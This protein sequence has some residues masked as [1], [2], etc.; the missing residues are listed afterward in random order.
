MMVSFVLSFFPRD[1]L[2]EILN[3]IESVSEDF[4]SYSYS[5]F[6]ISVPVS[7]FLGLNTTN[8]SYLSEFDFFYL[9]LKWT[10]EFGTLTAS[11]NFL[12][13]PLMNENRGPI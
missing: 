9:I 10:F 5:Q 8:V 3:L 2:D 6:I 11:I 13:E 1:V 12:T 7:L 4:P